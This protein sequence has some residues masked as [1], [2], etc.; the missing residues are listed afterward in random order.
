[1]FVEFKLDAQPPPMAVLRESL[2][3]HAMRD[4][5]KAFVDLRYVVESGDAPGPCEADAIFRVFEGARAPPRPLSDVE[6]YEL[7]R[8]RQVRQGFAL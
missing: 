6:I 4:E 1:M 5:S 3:V 8:K 2:V 7:R